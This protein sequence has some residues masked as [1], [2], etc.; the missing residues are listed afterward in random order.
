[1]QNESYVYDQNTRFI[2]TKA[3][4]PIP[5]KLLGLKLRECDFRISTLPRVERHQPINF[6][7]ETERVINFFISYP[8]Y[9]QR[10]PIS[11]RN[12]GHLASKFRKT[13]KDSHRKRT[14]WKCSYFNKIIT[15]ENSPPQYGGVTET[16]RRKPREEFTCNRNGTP[17]P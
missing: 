16:I 13:Q 17:S 11:P 2:K 7:T 1:M 5:G 6:S 10:K 8:F 3:F 9:W 15:G 14:K 4:L 12:P